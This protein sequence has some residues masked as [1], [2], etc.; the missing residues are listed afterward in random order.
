MWRPQQ[1]PGCR[2]GTAARPQLGG[3]QPVSMGSRA[4]SAALL[5]PWGLRGVS[6]QGQRGGEQG[7]G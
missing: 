3:Q 7:P 4:V 5:S 2:A 6:L 1:V